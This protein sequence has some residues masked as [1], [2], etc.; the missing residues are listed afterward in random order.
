MISKHADNAL[1]TCPFKNL[2]CETGSCM[3]YLKVNDELGCCSMSTF[4]QVY[5]TQWIQEKMED[6]KPDIKINEDK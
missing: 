4:N 6:C 3:A 5:V 2:T 1:K